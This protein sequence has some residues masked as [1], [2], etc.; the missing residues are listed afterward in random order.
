MLATCLACF[1][2]C[3]IL[4]YTGS[5]G[6]GGGGGG[7]RSR[8]TEN[9]T[10]IPRTFQFNPRQ[11]KHMVLAPRA[12]NNLWQITAHGCLAKHVSRQIIIAIQTPFSTHKNTLYPFNILA[13]RACLSRLYFR[14]TVILRKRAT[15]ILQTGSYERLDLVVH[16][17]R[18][19][20]WFRFTKL[21]DKVKMPVDFA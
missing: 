5:G 8:F 16:L 4:L 12:G 14:L 17:M 6:S 9:Q 10:V 20:A 21:Y 18:F 11:L 7:S 2:E 3:L 13:P 19:R 1:L 15:S